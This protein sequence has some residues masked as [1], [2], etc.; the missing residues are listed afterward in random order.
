MRPVPVP[1]G[2]SHYRTLFILHNEPLYFVGLVDIIAI[3]NEQMVR[4]AVDTNCVVDSC[5]ISQCQ[6]LKATQISVVMAL[7]RLI[8]PGIAEKRNGKVDYVFL[9]TDTDGY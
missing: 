6:I 3:D 4:V 9:S 8:A 1:Y 5:I 2:R 7:N